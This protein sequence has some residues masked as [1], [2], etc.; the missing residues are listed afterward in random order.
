MKHPPA[1]NPITETGMWSPAV[2]VG[3]TSDRRNLTSSWLPSIWGANVVFTD[4]TP[5]RRIELT[6]ICDARKGA[7]GLRKPVSHWPFESRCRSLGMKSKA[8]SRP[9]WKVMLVNVALQVE[10]KLPGS[11]RGWT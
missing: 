4:T 6:S 9:E 5:L 2:R 7:G 3:F 1:T 8:I 11:M 10:L